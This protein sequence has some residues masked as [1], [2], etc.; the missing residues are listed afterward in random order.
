MPS[1]FL[2]EK[3]SPHQASFWEN[4]IKNF[5]FPDI[6]QTSVY[7][8]PKRKFPALQDFEKGGVSF[9]G[10]ALY[11]AFSIEYTGETGRDRKSC[12]PV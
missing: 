11:Y 3:T 5:R 1:C 12:R 4:R 7:V 2:T 10:R 8:L 6:F 9:S